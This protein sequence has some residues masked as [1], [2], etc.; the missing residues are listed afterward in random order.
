MSRAGLW[1]AGAYVATALFALIYDARAAQGGNWITLKNI[2]P[3]LVTFP[4]SAPLAM[5]GYEPDLSN[6]LN[7]ALL[8]TLCAALIYWVTERIA[9][10]FR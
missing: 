8:L 2:V 10:L 1:A 7:V 5:M 4:V 9:S 6:R 3:F